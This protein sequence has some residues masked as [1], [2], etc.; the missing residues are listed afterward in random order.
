MNAGMVPARTA[1]NSSIHWTLALMRGVTQPL[2]LAVHVPVSEGG[3][4]QI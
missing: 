1:L 2:L 3:V 4:W